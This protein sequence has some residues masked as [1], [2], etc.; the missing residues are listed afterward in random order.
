MTW[1]FF[2][3]LPQ[4]FFFLIFSFYCILLTI[5]TILDWFSQKYD[6]PFHHAQSSLFT[7]RKVF[8]I[9]SFYQLLFYALRFSVSIILRS[10]L[11]YALI[12]KLDILCLTSLSQLLTI[13]FSFLFGPPLTPIPSLSLQVYS[14]CSPCAILNS[15]K[16]LLSPINSFLL[17]GHFVS[18]LSKNF[19]LYHSLVVSIIFWILFRSFWNI[20]VWFSSALGEYCSDGLSLSV[21]G[22]LVCFFPLWYLCMGCD[23]NPLLLGF[24]WHEFFCTFG[25]IMYVLGRGGSG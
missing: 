6:V 15:E 10:L 13:F 16:F 21:E 14:L 22:Y 5:L 17:T 23:H 19:Y 2:D 12:H 24:K 20:R 7:L 18:E 9:G 25:R 8:S 11:F 1:V 4:R 3:W